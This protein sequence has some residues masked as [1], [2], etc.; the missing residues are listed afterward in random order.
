MACIV[1]F[2]GA[3]GLRL[4]A[5]DGDVISRKDFFADRAVDVRDDKVER[6]AHGDE[7]AKERMNLR[8]EQRGCNAFARDVAEKEVE[9]AIVLDEVAIV[10]ADGAERS[11]V[12]ACVPAT[13][14]HVAWRQ[15]LVLELGG[16][17]E[18]S[19]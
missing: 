10:A 19:L 11:V 14:A 3:V 17:V 16:Q 2:Y 1:D 4:T 6:K 8:H 7:I 5:D 12:I 13:G 15:E 9:G 18:V